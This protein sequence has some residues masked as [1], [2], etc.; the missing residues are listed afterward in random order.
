MTDP[1]PSPDDGAP[2]GAGGVSDRTAAV[3]EIDAA[4]GLL[5]RSMMR[6]GL[7]RR[8]VEGLGIQVEP[9]LIEVI[10]IVTEAETDARDGVAIGTVAA[11]LG[12]DPSQ[13]SRLVAEAVKAGYVERLASP[14]DGRRSVLRPTAE[15]E[16]L[17]A[18]ARQRKRAL[19]LAHVEGWTEAELASFAAL[20]TRFSTLVRG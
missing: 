11:R 17:A 4:L 14:A 10:D 6:R 20:L 9:A 8:A 13:A 2:D 19:L 5:R 12:V 15:G 18:A 1:L 3:A 7:G 16:A